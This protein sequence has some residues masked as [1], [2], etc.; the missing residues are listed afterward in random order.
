MLDIII[1][2]IILVTAGI[3]AKL[4]FIRTVYQLA[5]SII[6]LMLAF[7][8]YPIIEVILKVTP[9]YI[10]IQAWIREM[11]P[12]VELATGLQQQAKEIMSVTEWLPSFIGEQL[13]QNNNP[14]I[15]ELLGVTSLI[16]YITVYLSD[17]CIVAIAIM[18]AWVVVKIG[19]SVF[20]GILDIVS[21]LP[22]LKTANKWAGFTVGLVKGLFIVWMILLVVPVLMIIPQLSNLDTLIE[23][24]ILTKSLY[25]NNII[26]QIINS[27]IF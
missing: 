20:V 23:G 5:S 1:I 11:L 27:I 16:E 3:A 21:K 6:A 13:V 8:V 25:E 26:L 17:L 15:Y 19:L 9:L 2:A 7:I 14:E 24:S 22:L 12:S 4:G 18:I 10:G